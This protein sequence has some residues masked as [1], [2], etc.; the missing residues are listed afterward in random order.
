METRDSAS[1]AQASRRC[2]SPYILDLILYLKR[3]LFGIIMMHSA[4][5]L[6]DGV[7]DHSECQFLLGVQHVYR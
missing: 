5:Q 6:I 1:M 7:Q 2:K 4:Y 3:T